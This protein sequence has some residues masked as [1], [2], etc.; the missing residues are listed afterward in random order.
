ME[1]HL[2]RKKM[3]L[4]QPR[5]KLIAL[6]VSTALAQ[7]V[8][9]NAARADSGFGVDTT[10][11]NAMNPRYGDFRDKDPDGLGQN[12]FSRTPTGFLE[13]KPNEIT[14]PT[15]TES[16]WTYKGSVEAGGLGGDADRKNAIFRKYKDLDNGLYLNNVSVDAEKPDAAAFFNAQG[17]SVGRKD[18]YYGAQFGRYNDWKVKVFYNE[19]THVF[20][21]SFK[22]FW[23]GVGTGNLTL[24]S[25]LPPAGG[26]T[27]TN[28]TTCT[29]FSSASYGLA[30]GSTQAQV[31]AAVAARL[32]STVVAADTMELSVQRKKAGARLDMNLTDSWKLFASYADEKRQGERPFGAT[33]GGGG[34]NGNLEVVEPIDYNTHDFLLGVQYADALNAL[35]ASLSASLF[36]NNI[37][38]LT[39][40]NPFL[41]ATTNGISGTAF[42]GG[43]FDLYPDNDSF[44]G[45]AEYSRLLPSLWNGRFTGVVSATGMRQNDKLI[46]PTTVDGVAF[47]NGSYAPNGS[48]NST[49]A[50]SQSSAHAKIDTRLVD[51]GLSL[52]PIND[53]DVRAKARYYET[54]NSTSFDACNPLTGQWGRLINDGTG[55]ALTT[56][57]QANGAALTAAQQT[58]LGTFLASNG[59]NKT[60]LI[61]YL[62]ANN[63]VPAAGNINLS[64]VPYEYKQMN[65]SLSGDY[66]L[67]RNQNISASIER[68]DYKRK[69]RERD[70]TWEDRIKLGYV[71]RALQDGTL[72]VSLETDRR[73]GS[74][75]NSDPYEE[76]Y[77]VS[78]GGIPNPGNLGTATANGLGFA[79]WVHNIEQ[80][81]KFDLADRD[82]NI[83]NARFNYALAESL[84]A[85][86]SLQ[87]KDAKFPDSTYGRNDHQR[88]NSL[89]V[90]LSWQPS[91]E[92]GVYGFY[93]FQN[94]RIHQSNV[95]PN[96]CNAG[97]TYYFYSNGQ[98]LAQLNGAAVPT[99]PAGATLVYT[100]AQVTGANWETV[101]GATAGP[102]NPLYPTSRG[103][104][105]EQ[106]DRNDTLGLGLKY[107]FGKAKVSFDYTYTRGYTSVS[108]DYNGVALGMTAA[109]MAA[110]GSGW[111]DMTFRQDVVTTNVIIPV[112]KR[113]T[114]RLMWMYEHA[115]VADWHYAGVDVNP[116]AGAGTAYNTANLYLD[117]GPKNFRANV[118]GAFARFDF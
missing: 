114:V 41:P 68:E 112:N 90:D 55:N 14:E 104:D 37:S 25:T 40:Q 64:N 65:L 67:S 108:Y 78:L 21:D 18:Q 76:F 49:S 84:D 101:C 57:V 69:Y 95:Q 58:A 15:K 47:A 59:C 70:K 118:F 39:F 110:A 23:G 45:K 98:V 62:A 56:Y 87:L 115:R 94:G 74:Q 54:D 43:T 117:T 27:C 7:L 8:T 81:R 79:G 29:Q 46:A 1:K 3:S 85:G 24:P 42:T 80:F 63:I 86:V 4:Q 26:A 91:L 20:T 96:S 102:L 61:N 12:E 51:L 83:L 19:T 28:S 35:N 6:C 111:P 73:R 9:T 31:N 17:G 60:A 52:Q 10:L 13:A 103:W 2:G 106:K 16:G 30:A 109:Q 48:W 11:G 36:R 72:R 89:N 93:S 32:S 50:L 88:L 22:T 116:T 44:N 34:G 99:T 105:V 66:K 97:T 113:T 71:N 92:L 82:Q 38:T 75:Y 53:L 5:V 33:W 107:D 77:S 100:T